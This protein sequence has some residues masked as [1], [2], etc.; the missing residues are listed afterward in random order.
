[1]N[2]RKILVS[3]RAVSP[4][5]TTIFLTASQPASTPDSSE[6]PRFLSRES[7][8]DQPVAEAPVVEG[9]AG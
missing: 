4:D 2:N 6:P 7:P 1:M 3:A 8:P 9:A 5:R